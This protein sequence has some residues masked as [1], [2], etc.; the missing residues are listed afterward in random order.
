M[1]KIDQECDAEEHEVSSDDGLYLISSLR[2]DDRTS[3][4][5]SLDICGK[6]TRFLLDTGAT[7][8]ILPLA[9]VPKEAKLSPPD[10]VR[11]YDGSILPTEGT[12][13]LRVFN[14]RTKQRFSVV[15][16][17]TVWPTNSGS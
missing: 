15:L 13:R 9:S 11:L 4:F 12:I 17:N 6:T 1:R 16:F 3:L 10:Q 8:N 2:R 5:T 14:P 7:C